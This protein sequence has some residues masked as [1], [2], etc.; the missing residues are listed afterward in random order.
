[1]PD[2]NQMI[3]LTWSLEGINDI[4]LVPADMQI[5]LWDVEVNSLQPLVPEAVHGLISPTANY[6]AFRTYSAEDLSSQIHI[7]NTSTREVVFTDAIFGELEPIWLESSLHMGVFASNGRYFAYLDPNLNLKIVDIE[8]TQQITAVSS[9]STEPIWSTNSHSLLFRDPQDNW[10]LFD[11]DQSTQTALTIQG[12][13]RAKEPQW[14]FDGRYLSFKV[15]TT[16]CQED[17]VILEI[18]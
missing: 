16:A 13:V 10:T 7:F 5:Q 18:P 9:S 2:S 12:G 11:L 4:E 15:C 14:S 3:V 17:A 1:M 8:T 6:L